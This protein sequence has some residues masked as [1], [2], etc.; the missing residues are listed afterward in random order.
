[1]PG[2]PRAVLL[3][4]WAIVTALLRRIGSARRGLRAFVENYR[5]D[6]LVALTPEERLE[7]ASFG[8]CIACGL[9]DEGEGERMARSG[10]AYPGVMQIVLASSRNLPDV[11]AAARAIELVPHEVLREK[12]ASCPTLVPISRLVAFIDAKARQARDAGG[13]GGGGASR[14][15]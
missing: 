1:M 4:A 6:R 14:P 2:L 9:C 12:E 5:D 13:A 15:S 8:R 10:G 3:L 11:D 7:M